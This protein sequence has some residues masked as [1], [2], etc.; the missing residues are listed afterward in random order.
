M[1]PTG[2]YRYVQGDESAPSPGVPCVN[3]LP[4]PLGV[5]G[6][7]RGGFE[8]SFVLC[9]SDSST[10]TWLSSAA[11]SKSAEVRTYRL[12]VL[13]LKDCPPPPPLG[14][15]ATR[16]WMLNECDGA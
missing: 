4:Y 14:S 16:L 7:V 12:Y 1:L 11:L 13:V 10:K 5:L 9:S 15:G 3:L 8:S 2:N 6:P